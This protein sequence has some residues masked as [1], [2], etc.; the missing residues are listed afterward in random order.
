MFKVYLLS[1][2][3]NSINHC[4]LYNYP[5]VIGKLLM[6]LKLRGKYLNQVYKIYYS[7]ILNLHYSTN[8]LY[9]QNSVS[10]FPSDQQPLNLSS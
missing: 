2:T 4:D 7:F 3:R 6:V 5:R 9:K 10:L 8:T 1:W